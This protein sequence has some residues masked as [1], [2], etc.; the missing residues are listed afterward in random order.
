MI[1][2]I[3]IYIIIHE[4]FW[5]ISTEILEERFIYTKIQNSSLM[6]QLYSNTKCEFLSIFIER[7]N[8]LGEERGK[9]IYNSFSTIDTCCS[10][11]CLDIERGIAMNC[12]SNI[13][14]VYEN[15]IPF[16]GSLCPNSIIK[17]KR[18]NTIYAYSLL[19]EPFNCL[20]I[21]S[22]FL[23]RSCLILCI[24]WIIHSYNPIMMGVLTNIIPNIWGC[25]HIW[26]I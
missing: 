2:R 16:G 12:F 10:L 17:I 9:H 1:P 6:I 11:E 15:N 22:V 23:N 18:F 21:D 13:A 25:I 4:C 14:Y 19:I 7:K 5:I 26:K 20:V 3:R 8:I 24:L